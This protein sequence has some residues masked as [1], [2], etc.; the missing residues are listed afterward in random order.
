MPK[1]KVP[2][3]LGIGHTNKHV[4]QQLCLVNNIER[5]AWA[6]TERRLIAGR[7]KPPFLAGDARDSILVSWSLE[8][9]H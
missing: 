4:S 3:L 9:C 5:F 7:S 2:F 6:H 1:L 8:A